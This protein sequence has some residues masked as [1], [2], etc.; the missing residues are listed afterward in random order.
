LPWAIATHPRWSKEGCVVLTKKTGE[1][2]VLKPQADNKAA[3]TKGKGKQQKP[4]A[5][6]PDVQ[7]AQ[8][9]PKE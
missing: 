7:G 4:P 8:D 5:D 2:K 9:D 6:P 3:G 1:N